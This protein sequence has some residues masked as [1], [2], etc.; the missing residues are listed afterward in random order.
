MSVEYACVNCCFASNVASSQI[1]G[2]NEYIMDTNMFICVLYCMCSLPNIS[3]C[4]HISM[5]S[6]YERND[7]FKYYINIP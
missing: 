7:Y 5:N 1:S 2:Y 6:R 3:T 4:V